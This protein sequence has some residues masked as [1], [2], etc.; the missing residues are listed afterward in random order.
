[1]ALNIPRINTADPQS[2]EQIA[3]LRAKLAP[4]GDVVSEAGRKKTIDVFGEPLSPMQVVERICR[5]V[6]RRGLEA[7][8]E[9]T[10]RLDNKQF[11]PAELRVPADELKAAHKAA[12][13][14]FLDSVKRIRARLLRFQQAILHRDV[15]IQLE[16]GSYLTQR[17]LPLRRVG[18]CVPGGAAAY[19]S[20]VLM[21]VVP[22]QAA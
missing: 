12:D 5:D 11:A 1:M 22:A 2:R 15:T 21:T 18:V 9:Y 13:P 6:R 19:P 3:A 4:D 10:A 20:T 17:Y 16:G 7:V 14:A 8:L